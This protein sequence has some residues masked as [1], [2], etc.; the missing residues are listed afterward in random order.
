MTAYRA[1]V[2][3]LPDTANRTHLI[4]MVEAYAACEGLTLTVVG[5]NFYLR[6][7]EPKHEV[8]NVTPI[9]GALSWM[10]RNRGSSPTPPNAA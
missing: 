6:G 8:H 5:S 1:I 2:L 7:P 9:R 3:S 10:R 4:R